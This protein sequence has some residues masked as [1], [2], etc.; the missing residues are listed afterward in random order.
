MDRND[1]DLVSSHDDDMDIRCQTSNNLD[2]NIEHDCCSPKVAHVGS[3]Q[4]TLSSK[5]DSNSDGVLKIGMEFESDEYAYKFYCKY[6]GLV[7]FSVRKD[8]V[9]RSKVHGRVVSRKFTC[10]K[11]GYRRK[12]KRDVNVKKHRKE[13]RTGCLA[14]MII[15]RQPDGIYRITHFEE[16]HN[17]ENV[18]PSNAQNLQELPSQGTIDGAGVTEADS[19]INLE[20]QSQLAFQLLGRQFGARENLDYPAIDFENYLKSGR[21]RDLKEGEAGRLLYYFQRQHFENPSFFYAIQLDVDDKISNIFWADDNMVVDYDHFGN[22]VCLDTTYRTQKDFRPLVQ[23][24]GLNHHRQVVIFGAA[25]MYDETIDSLKWLFRT[26]I[27]AMSRKKPEAILTDQDATIIQAIDSEI[28]ET[29]HRVCIWQMYQNALKHLSHVTKD[30]DS[31]AKVLR[32]CIFDHEDEEDFIHAWDDMVDKF[33]LRQNEWLRWMFREK[34]NW[35]V[36]YGKNSFFIDVK[37]THLVENFSNNLKNYLNSDLDVLQFFTHFESMVN[38]QRYNELEANYDMGRC[39]PRLMANVVLLKHASDLYTPKAFEVFQREYEKCLNIVVNL[40]SEN[41]SLFEYKANTYGQPR[42]YTVTFNSSDGTVTCGCMKFEYVGILCCHALKVLDHRNIKVVP[43]CYILKRWTRDARVESFRECAI[44]VEEESPKSITASRYRKLCQSLLKISARAAESNQA[45]EFA[46]R[47]LE[48]VM[49]GVEKI[50]TLKPSEE[51]QAIT[52]SSTGAYASES[53]QAEIFLDRNAIEGQDD[54]NTFRGTNERETTAPD[55]DPLNN[56]VEKI[57]KTK[58]SQNVHSLPPDTVASISCP[59]PAYVSSASSSL[60]PVTQGFYNFEAN[61]VVQ[62]L[63]QPPNLS[64]AQ[65]PNPDIYQPPNLFSNQHDS[66]SQAQLLQESL[67]RSP[68]QEPMSHR[69]QLRQWISMSNI[70]IRPHSFIMITDTE[71]QMA[72]ILGP[73]ND[74]KKIVHHSS[75]LVNVIL[76]LYISSNACLF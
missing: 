62:C 71:H 31:F 57:S 35:A 72:N 32:S 68:F 41:G 8:W 56:L 20:R 27:E 23:F 39:T 63:Y 61:Q 1:D 54:S 73:N 74:V 76:V 25:L 38:K 40:F 45:F 17:H 48:G 13:T 33:T 4:S 28:P 34:E 58:T 65:Q 30:A 2:L 7:G 69:N 19:T 59:Q 50:L 46:A 52:S 24:L 18:N 6:A 55:E 70:H 67:I 21:I 49:Q 66:P 12:D 26:F 36:V 9:N 43:T 60:N 3:V 11:E 75:H 16:N 64:M 44:S 47:Q 15:T 10:S 37:S 5:D 53:E 29:N 22:V 14:H 42:E 51:T